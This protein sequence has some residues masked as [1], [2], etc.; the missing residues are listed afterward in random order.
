MFHRLE[1]GSI[2]MTSGD[3]NSRRAAPDE[4]WLA[5]TTLSDPNAALWHSLRPTGRRSWLASFR[6]HVESLSVLNGGVTP[7]W[8]F[9]GALALCAGA[10]LSIFGRVAAPPSQDPAG[11]TTLAAESRAASA[12]AAVA[13]EPAAQVRMGATEFG[14]ARP[15]APRAEASQAAEATVIHSLSPSDL[16][17]S[18]AD[19][20]AK[21]K[22][23]SSKKKKAHAAASR[24]AAKSRRSAA[25]DTTLP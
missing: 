22:N 11:L 7:R 13:A 3:V 9:V 25:L 5:A 6:L 18:P 24:R 4:T 16:A 19:P 20:G 10:G 2:P 12:T 23:A 14:V 15:N 8:L 17:L 1:E 21:A